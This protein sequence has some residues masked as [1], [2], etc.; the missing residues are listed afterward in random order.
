MA[1]APT[2]T[3]TITPL[4][5][6][7]RM[8]YIKELGCSLSLLLGREPHPGGSDLRVLPPDSP[9]PAQS[10]SPSLGG[11]PSHQTVLR[12]AQS[13]GIRPHSPV[14]SSRLPLPPPH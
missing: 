12:V 9:A 7:E 11:V 5:T 6:D 2:I 4:V 10:P 13:P 14:I 3:I 8:L 1:T